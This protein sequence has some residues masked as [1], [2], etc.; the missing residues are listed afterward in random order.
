MSHLLLAPSGRDVFNSTASPSFDLPSS[1]DKA[2]RWAI[3]SSDPVLSLYKAACDVLNQLI[4]PQTD[5]STLDV[6]IRLIPPQTDNSTLD[7]LIRL[8]PPSDR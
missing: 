5:N 3:P 7:V 2:H 8:I 4:P 6:L 1:L